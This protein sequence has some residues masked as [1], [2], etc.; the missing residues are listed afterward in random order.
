MRPVEHSLLQGA[1]ACLGRRGL[2]FI[3]MLASYTCHGR[4]PRFL[5]ALCLEPRSGVRVCSS[6]VMP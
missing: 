1:L 4:L 2:S 3:A 5:G 6:I